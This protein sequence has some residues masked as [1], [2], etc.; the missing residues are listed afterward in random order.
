[1]NHAGTETC[2]RPER[3]PDY[4]V[5]TTHLRFAAGRLQQLWVPRDCWV[6]SPSDFHK[7]GVWADIPEEKNT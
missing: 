7:F 3:V 1:M 6:M 2:P 5:P 4:Y